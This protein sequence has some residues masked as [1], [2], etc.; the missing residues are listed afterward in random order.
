[1]YDVHLVPEHLF[2][3]LYRQLKHEAN[4]KSILDANR[5]M[6]NNSPFTNLIK[7]SFHEPRS[8]HGAMLFFVFC[9]NSQ[10]NYQQT[11]INSIL[12]TA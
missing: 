12:P 1:M 7:Y 9:H 2:T 10:S 4:K 6:C 5:S 8:R 3:Q 11:S